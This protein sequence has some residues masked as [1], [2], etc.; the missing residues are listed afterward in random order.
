[1]NESIRGWFLLQNHHNFN[2]IRI[3]FITKMEIVV[4]S[5]KFMPLFT[6]IKVFA[7]IKVFELI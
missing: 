1:M 5:A 3:F 4:Y 7:H 6:H 2:S